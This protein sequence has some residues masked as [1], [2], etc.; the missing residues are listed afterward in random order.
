MYT[1]G[2]AA[3]EGPLCPKSSAGRHEALYRLYQV[4]RVLLVHPPR[5][6]AQSQ[7]HGGNWVDG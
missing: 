6:R 7:G 2:L 1:A 3:L 5:I 4:T